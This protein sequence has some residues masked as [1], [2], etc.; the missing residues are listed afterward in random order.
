MGVAAN[1]APGLSWKEMGLDVE[2]GVGTARER[3]V[4]A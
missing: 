2:K 3:G 1:L 4:Q